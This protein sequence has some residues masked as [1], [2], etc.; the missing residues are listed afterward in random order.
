MNHPESMTSAIRSFSSSSS[1]AYCALTSTSGIRGT[2]A[3]SSPPSSA[4]EPGSDEDDDE[5]NDRDVDEAEV[6]V[7]G[8][9]ARAERPAAAG[10]PEAP[11]DAA[12]EGE[13]REA[14]ERHPRQPGGDRDERA[15][16]RGHAAEEDRPAAPALEPAFRAF[17]VVRAEMKPA[18]A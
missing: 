8:R 4:D 10:E 18:A 13:E 11:G 9:P 6:V 14:A 2:A 15:D 16:N 7:E 5:E 12:E 3:Q 1:G 17:E